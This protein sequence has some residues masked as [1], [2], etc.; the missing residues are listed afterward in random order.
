MTA[1]THSVHLAC[2]TSETGIGRDVWC[3]CGC[4]L[5]PSFPRRAASITPVHCHSSA[6]APADPP[7]GLVLSISFVVA[8]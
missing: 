6:G 8:V 7:G 1:D 2:C 3:L 5:G 4:V